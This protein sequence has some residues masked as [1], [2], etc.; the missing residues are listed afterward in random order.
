M[1]ISVFKVVHVTVLF[2]QTFF[3]AT[4]SKEKLV[5]HNRRGVALNLHLLSE[6]VDFGYIA[7]HHCDVSSVQIVL[8]H[9]ENFILS[10]FTE[11]AV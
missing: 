7:L 5:E 1:G 6:L 10:N 8:L 4:N 11:L 3:S 2:L 9:Q